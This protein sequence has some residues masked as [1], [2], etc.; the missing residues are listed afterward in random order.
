MCT[1]YAGLT[2]YMRKAHSWRHQFT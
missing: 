1:E 2:F